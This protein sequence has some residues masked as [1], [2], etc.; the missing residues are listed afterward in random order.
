M[1]AFPKNVVKDRRSGLLVFI[2]VMISRPRD[3]ATLSYIATLS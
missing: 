3:E 1:D 2:D